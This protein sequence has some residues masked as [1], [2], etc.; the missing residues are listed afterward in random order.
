MRKGKGTVYVGLSGGVDSAVSA[1][2]LQKAGYTV[3]GVFI[4]IALPG[5]PC[6]VALDRQAAMRVAAHLRI[7]FREIDLSVAYH[8]RVFEH[9]VSEF[10]RG[11]TPNPDTLCNREIKFGVFYDW[12]RAAGAQYV[13]TGHYARV[14]TSPDTKLYVSRDEHKDQSYFLWMVPQEH[15]LHTL[16]PVGALTKPEVRTLA[17]S[18][19]LP[20]AARKDSQGL[21]FLGDISIQ[22]MLQRELV[23]QKGSV[24]SEKGE[25][26][27]EH[28]GAS[29][30]TLGQRHGFLLNPHTP[31]TTAQ[32]VIAKDTAH[33]TITV[34]PQQFPAHASKTVLT[35]LN[36][37]WIGEVSDG[38]YLVRF[39]Y[40]QP[41][42]KATLTKT[43]T[44]AIVELAQPHYV[45]VGQSLVMYR[46]DGVGLRC[47]GGG[48]IDTAQL[49]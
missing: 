23:L 13:A 42:I 5:Y 21:C 47:V 18:F 38:S 2:L 16:F 26:I 32:Y 3:V 1:A 29:L 36:T 6:P 24:L 34:S 40:R 37:N 39:R 25:V 14:Q 31:H 43:P 45:P 48:V 28:D 20:N 11:R 46:E 4:R 7:P 49:Q 12:A 22:D 27:G 15:L 44:G 30:Y 35:L 10:A 8:K 17:R 19:G 41:L 9:T 33:N